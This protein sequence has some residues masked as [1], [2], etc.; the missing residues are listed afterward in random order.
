MHFDQVRVGVSDYAVGSDHL[1]TTTK[2]DYAAEAIVRLS[3][4]C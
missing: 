4:S 3:I 1:E 2:C